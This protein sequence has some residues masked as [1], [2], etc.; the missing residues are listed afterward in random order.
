MANRIGRNFIILTLGQ[1][2][3]RFM[4][5]VTVI[6]LTRTLLDEGFGIITFATSVLTYAELV[7]QFGFDALG[8]REAARA[9]RPMPVLAGQVL[10]IRLALLLPAFVGLYVFTLVA[11]IEPTT[12]LVILLYGISLLTTA[13]DLNWAF[14][15][16]ER[17]EPPAIAEV[18]CLLLVTGGVW[19]FVNDPTEVIRVPIIFIAA[20][21]LTVG[22]LG[23]VFV[24]TYGRIT[25]RQSWSE[26]R[27]LA[28]EALPLAGARTVATTLSNFD[29][30]MVGLVLTVEA[31]GHY[32][33]AYRVVWMP[34][35]ITQAYFIALRPTIARAYVTGIEPLMPVLYRSTRLM[36]AL[37]IGITVGGIV[38]AKPLI[39]F[40]FTDAY[41]PATLP[42]QILLLA[43][44]LQTLNGHYRALLISFNLQS[45][46]FRIMAVVALLNVVLNLILIRPLGIFGASLAT[47]AARMIVLGASY[48]AVRRMI[49]PVPLGRFLPKPLLCAILMAAALFLTDD[50]HVIIRLMIGGL[51][52]LVALFVFGVMSVSETVALIRTTITRKN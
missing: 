10:T 43:F 2:V 7:V 49:R 26:L 21:L 23:F 9:E 42:F 11:D 15:G 14:L 30:V 46:E 12:R 5:F 47:L 18:I 45:I 51:V 48:F 39:V 50:W 19:V 35:M 37:T 36:T 34:I 6:I 13:L 29:L 33:A 20:R 24:R 4:A 8:P 27:K 32:G 25:F 17:M 44:L 38:L 31:A 41:L 40:L 52:Y 22:G 3:G 16:D 1:L 28:K